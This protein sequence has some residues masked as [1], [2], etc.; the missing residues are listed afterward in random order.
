MATEFCPNG[1]DFPWNHELFGKPVCPVCARGSQLQMAENKPQTPT[2]DKLAREAA[3]QR[4]IDSGTARWNGERLC[5]SNATPLADAI[6]A[7][8]RPLEERLHPF[9]TVRVVLQ[10]GQ[11]VR[12]VV[13]TS[14]K[15][16]GAL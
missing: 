2:L 11:V 15:P 3:Q 7:A 13:E 5:V 12:V 10:D 1:H 9:A 14:H 8:L 6:H 4:S 16:G